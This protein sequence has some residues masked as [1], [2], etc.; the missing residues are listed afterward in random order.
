MRVCVI[1]RLYTIVCVHIMLAN[2]VHVYENMHADTRGSFSRRLTLS[3]WRAAPPRCA[4][5]SGGRTWSWWP[6]LSAVWFWYDVCVCAF[7]TARVCVCPRVC[8]CGC[9]VFAYTQYTLREKALVEVR[10]CVN[11]FM[12]VH[13]CVRSCVCV[14]AFSFSCFLFF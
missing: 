4:K 10:A 14:F 11:R 5:S 13:A 6:W 3:R 9:S 1:D 7:L 2:N 12:C 8:F